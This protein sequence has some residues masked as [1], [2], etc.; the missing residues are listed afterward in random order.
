[1]PP[2]APPKPLS[3]AK[4]VVRMTSIR[5]FTGTIPQIRI[6]ASGQNQAKASITP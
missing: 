2:P 6:S 1:M 3:S 4:I 5:A